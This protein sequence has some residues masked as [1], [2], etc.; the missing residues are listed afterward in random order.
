MKNSK[1][2]EGL[3]KGVEGKATQGTRRFG[4][5][6]ELLLDLWDSGRIQAWT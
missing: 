4:E 1:T 5:E 6:E 3:G 2:D